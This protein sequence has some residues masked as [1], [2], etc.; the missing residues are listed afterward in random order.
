[1]NHSGRNY[2][3]FIHQRLNHFDWDPVQICFMPSFF[4][5]EQHVIE[6]SHRNNSKN[7]I[8]NPILS[9][10]FIYVNVVV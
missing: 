7:K 2:E 1:M 5:R 8:V 4:S 9:L 6:G 3:I 10:K